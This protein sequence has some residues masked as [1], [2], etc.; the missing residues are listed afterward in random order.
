MQCVFQFLS[1]FLFIKTP[2]Y[3]T[4]IHFCPKLS[5][6]S[7]PLPPPSPYSLRIQTFLSGTLVTLL[8]IEMQSGIGSL[9]FLNLDFCVEKLS[10]LENIIRLTTHFLKMTTLGI[11]SYLLTTQY[12]DKGLERSPHSFYQHGFSRWQT[13]RQ[14]KLLINE[15]TGK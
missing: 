5:S 8:V 10:Q 6:S 14:I 11:T 2:L 7:T 15:S 12:D 3:P 4:K 13:I 9:S 1:N